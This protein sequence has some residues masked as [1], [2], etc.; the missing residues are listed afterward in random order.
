[1]EPFIKIVEERVKKALLECG[2]EQEV[3]LN[4]SSRPDLGQYQYN[5]VMAIAKQYNQHCI[6]RDRRPRR[7]APNAN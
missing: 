2:Y 1:M 3:T 6:C 4:V 5:G 7:S